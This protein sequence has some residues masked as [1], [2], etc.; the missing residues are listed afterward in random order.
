M[1]QRGQREPHLREPHLRE[2]HLREPHLR[3][4]YGALIN[5]IE[6]SAADRFLDSGQDA[7]RATVA[8]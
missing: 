3:E 1:P 4:R 7:G 8:R 5:I 2:P 6:R